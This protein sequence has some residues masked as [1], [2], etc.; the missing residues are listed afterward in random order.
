MQ[1]W[2]TSDHHF[3][4]ERIIEY[5]AESRC[6]KTVEE[7]DTAYIEQWNLQV[8]PNDLVFHLGDFCWGHLVDARRYVRNLNGKIRMLE[9]NH[10]RWMSEYRQQYGKKPML[11][12][13][14]HPVFIRSPITQVRH[15]KRKIIL[16]HYPMRSWNAS[17]HG[18]W[19]LYGHVHNPIPPWGLS[20]DVGV[21]GSGGMLYSFDT[22]ADYMTMRREEVGDPPYLKQR[23]QEENSVREVD[24]GVEAQDNV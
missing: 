11:S 5:Q 19:H 18:S 13:S 9:G 2:F 21:D 8:A 6:F 24:N 10:D 7:M 14:G 1:I 17:I 4:H 16:C 3:G 12:R 23:A 20:M 22:V 15:E